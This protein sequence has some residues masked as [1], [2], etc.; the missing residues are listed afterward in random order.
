MKFNTGS[1]SIGVREYSFLE[2]TGT[3]GLNDRFFGDVSVLARVEKT[4]KMIE[5][6]ASLKVNARLICDRCAEEFITTISK[7]YRMVYFF[8]END[9]AGYPEEEIS[10]LPSE[11]TIIDIT[12]DV[13]QFIQLA[14][15]LKILCRI[16]C[17]GLCQLCGT[18]LNENTCSCDDS[19]IDPRWEQLNKLLNQN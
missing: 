16:D 19:F 3:V 4:S 9:K 14:I 5:L 17:K 2:E 11:N 18:N 12:D 1:L 8:D 15:P 10:V 13:R 7:T 6:Q